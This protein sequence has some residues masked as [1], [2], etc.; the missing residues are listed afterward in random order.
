M[1]SEASVAGNVFDAA[2]AAAAKHIKSEED[3]GEKPRSRTLFRGLRGTRRERGERRETA[4]PPLVAV[5]DHH[6][7]REIKREAPWGDGEVHVE[8][9]VGQAKGRRDTPG[10]TRGTSDNKSKKKLLLA[11]RTALVD[12]RAAGEAELQ[13]GGKAALM[14]GVGAGEAGRRAAV[15]DGAGAGG[16][17]LVEAK[18]EELREIAVVVVT[19]D[20]GLQADGESRT[21]KP[22]K[23]KAR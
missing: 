22:A 10:E 6:P 4:A 21:E 19:R 5:A 11:N 8:V 15:V 16:L 14:D 3:A 18:R 12:G 7:P 23:K 13:A 9:R 17:P 1:E 2:A 20:A